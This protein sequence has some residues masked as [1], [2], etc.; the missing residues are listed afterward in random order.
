MEYTLNI[1][2]RGKN[3]CIDSKG[4]HMH[5]ESAASGSI[6]SRYRAFHSLIAEKDPSSPLR[7]TTWSEWRG[8]HAFMIFEESTILHVERQ[9]KR[10][11]PNRDTF[12]KRK[13][14]ESEFWICPL[15]S[16]YVVT[17]TGRNTVAQIIYNVQCRNLWHTIFHALIFL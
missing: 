11:R 4:F 5:T 10:Q 16:R 7:A 3:F 17:F 13:R 15:T 1:D 6:L 2:P 9:Y 8:A 14:R 12:L